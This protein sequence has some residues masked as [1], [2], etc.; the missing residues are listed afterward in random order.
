ME[1]KRKYLWLALGWT[2]VVTYFCLVSFNELPKI[3]EK[4]FDKFG[5]ITFHFGLTAFWFLYF[6]FQRL[7]DNKKALFRAFLFSFVY[8]VTIEIIQET[9]TDT[10]SGDVMDVLANVI[11]SILAVV[12]FSTFVKPLKKTA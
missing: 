11:G 8:G 6:R 7:N 5:H 12:T 3:G 9:L 10:R 1:R 2:A 4:N